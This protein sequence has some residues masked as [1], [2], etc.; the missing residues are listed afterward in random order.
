MEKGEQPGVSLLMREVLALL[1]GK[2]ASGVRSSPDSTDS[3]C[4]AGIGT[5]VV[6]LK[7]MLLVVMLYC[8][9]FVF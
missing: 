4:G 3:P 6:S 8:I 7:S 9:F 2:Q 5:Q 1:M